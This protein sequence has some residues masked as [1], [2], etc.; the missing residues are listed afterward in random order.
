[1]IYLDLV[2]GLNFAVDLL[3]LL[4]TNRLAGFPSRPG[5]CTAAAALGGVY[6]GICLLPEFAFLGNTLLRMTALSAMAVLAFGT[7]RSALRR[8]ILFLFLSMALGGIALG[9]GSSGGWHL[10]AA[11]AG[12]AA[13]CI[14]GFGGKAGGRQFVAVEIIHR[15][16]CATLTALQDTGNT[17]RDPIS[18]S[19]V[20]VAGPDAAEK[21][22]GLTT[23]QLRSPADTLPANPGLRL[24]PYRSVGS[25]GGML[26]AFR[27][28]M[29][30][31]GGKISK[32]LVAFAPESIGND[33]YQ[34]LT[35]GTL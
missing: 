1:M 9:I 10:V 31:I 8:G 15:G 34:A 18:G 6:G 32:T 16:V 12:V 22:L 20:V 28:E 4:G 21:L 24:I 26:L 25:S 7:D 14:L 30:R 13:L 11:A 2:M 29:I 5:R 35:G 3:L 27:P 19:A 17:L 23:D 33:G